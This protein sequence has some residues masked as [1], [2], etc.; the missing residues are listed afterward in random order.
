MQP[1]ASLMHALS[2]PDD[3]VFAWR[4]GELCIEAKPQ[5]NLHAAIDDAETA[6]Q[7]IQQTSIN[8]FH[9]PA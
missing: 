8:I 4:N 2:K 3:Y 5:N 1:I 7:A 6:Y 9:A